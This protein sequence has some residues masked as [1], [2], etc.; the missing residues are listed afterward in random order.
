[1]TAAARPHWP[2]ATAA[3]VVFA[4][5]A[6]SFIEP[7]SALATSADRDA[8]AGSLLNTFDVTQRPRRP[9]SLPTRAC[10]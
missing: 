1:M 7:R 9:L 5:T 3:V 6:C 8:Q 10:P 2:W 4:G